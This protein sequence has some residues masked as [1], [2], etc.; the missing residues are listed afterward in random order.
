MPQK[1]EKERGHQPKLTCFCA[2]C[3]SSVVRA[4]AAKAGGPGFESQLKLF[5]EW[6]L[7]CLVQG[8][9]PCTRNICA[10]LVDF[11]LSAVEKWLAI[12][13]NNVEYG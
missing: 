13:C 4:T 10:K 9:L 2:W 11:A 1:R 3:C 6:W 12:Q 7:S 8:L 5:H